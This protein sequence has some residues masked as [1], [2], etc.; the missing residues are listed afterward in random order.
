MAV[1]SL[2]AIVGAV[3]ICVLYTYI[4]S[5]LDRQRIRRLA[6]QH[7]A[8]P[9]VFTESKLPFNLEFLWRF[10]NASKNNE[11]IFTIL[12]EIYAKN[13][14]TFESPGLFTNSR[15]NTID[16]VNSQ[17]ILA[18]QFQGFELGQQLNRQLLLGKCIFTEDGPFWEHSRAMFKPQFAREQINNL[19]ETEVASSASL[20]VDSENGDSV[21]VDLLSMFYRFTMDTATKFL[22]GESVNTQISAATGHSGKLTSTASSLAAEFGPEMNFVD[23]LSD[24]QLWITQRIRLQGLHWLIPGKR[25][26]TANA[27]VRKYAAHYVQ[28][29]LKAANDKKGSTMVSSS[30]GYSLLEALIESTRDPDELRDQ[31]LGLLLAGRDTTASLLSWTVLL[32]ARHP[33]KFAK[34]RAAALE[35][36]GPYTADTSNIT[37]ETLKSC[38]YL[39]LI[40]REALRL[41]D[42][43]PP[44]V[45]FAARDTTL[46]R[47]GGQIGKTP[48]FVPKGK[49]VSFVLHLLHR[50][51]DLW[52]P[53]ADEFK[54]ERWEKKKMDWNFVPFSGGP[55][56]CLG[57]QYALTEAVY[58]I[59]RMLQRFEKIDWL[60][61]AGEPRKTITFTM[62]P[63]NG[64]PVRLT[65]AK[66]GAS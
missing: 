12:A 6:I 41:Y 39:Q 64:V 43:S 15:L 27:F 42:P 48:I 28:L 19:R 21:E 40:L 62:Q 32:L 10:I 61:E 22:F 56:I 7:R 31:I 66:A 2:Q 50:R 24:A 49:T 3:G 63:R 53:D 30:A 65:Y 58:L 44:N 8:S 60:G 52:G 17:A 25:G 1:F 26:R 11:D 35:H 51:K 59:V 20:G 57:Q 54:P 4:T 33:D 46:P 55:R 23:A 13:G 29:A 18:S 37:F 34:L 38:R 45:R 36:F 14:T 16:P 9:P 5:L 47:G